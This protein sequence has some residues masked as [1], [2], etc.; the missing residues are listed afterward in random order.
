MGTTLP[1]NE[2]RRR[3]AEREE[4]EGNAG[5]GSI[6]WKEKMSSVNHDVSHFSK[7]E[8]CFLQLCTLVA[9]PRASG[10]AIPEFSDVFAATVVCFRD[11]SAPAS[12]NNTNF[13]LWR[14]GW[15]GPGWSWGLAVRTHGLFGTCRR[16]VRT[17]ARYQPET[18]QKGPGKIFTFLAVTRDAQ[19]LFI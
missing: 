6:L 15:F 10:G 1:D 12:P 8:Y 3:H 9:V 16:R 7:R 17:S 11:F 13:L 18:L 4:R 5:G 14:C 19:N 2:R